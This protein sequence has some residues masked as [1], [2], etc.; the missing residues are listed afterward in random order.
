MEVLT[1]PLFI[2]L[3][4]AILYVQ[5]RYPGTAVLH[6]VIPAYIGGLLL[7]LVLPHTAEMVSLQEGISSGMVALSIPLMLFVV[8]IRRWALAGR[9]ALLSLLLATVAIILSVALGHVLVRNVLD[10]SPQIGGLLVGVYTGGTPNLAALRLALEVESS[11]YVTVHTVDLLVSALYILVIL[12]IGKTLVSRDR[13]PSRTFLFGKISSAYSDSTTETMSFRDVIRRSMMVRNS[14]AMGSALLIVGLSIG[15]SLMIPGTNN[16]VIIILALTT[17]S[18]AATFIPGVSRLSSSFKLGE[19]FILVF[20]VTV[21]SMADI[22]R[23]FAASPAIIL[24]MSVAVFGS[25]VIHFLLGRLFRLRNATIM[26]TSISAVCSPPFIS[27]LAPI[28]GDPQIIAA[29]ITTGIIG[30]AAGNYLGVL[31]AWLLT[32]I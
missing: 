10:F 17:L 13:L 27:M 8:D 26:V 31:V 21:G 9:E 7:S 25:L 12:G 32:F 14:A 5:H 11:L 18:L 28:V 20:S 1:A 22:S 4:L 2:A 15:V 6:P 24:F 30:Y 3:P 19:F 16:T 23:I 29:G